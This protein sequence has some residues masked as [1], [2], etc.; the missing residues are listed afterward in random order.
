MADPDTNLLRAHRWKSLLGVGITMAVIALAVVTAVFFVPMCNSSSKDD[1][2]NTSKTVDAG[3][4]VVHDATLAQDSGP[5]RD[6]IVALSKFGFFSIDANAK[7]TIW[8]DNKNIGETPLTRLPLTPGPHKV[9]AFGPRG[10][11]KEFS[12]TIYGG[13]DTEEPAI[14]W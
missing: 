8:I 5:N 13:R 10:K 11:K 14:A 4:A 3:I 1:D 6:D 9:K 7:T 2:G 12:I